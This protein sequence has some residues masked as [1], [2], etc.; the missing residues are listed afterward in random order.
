MSLMSALSNAR[1][2]LAVAQH[3]LDV[4]A[5]NV[6]NVNTEGYSRKL[7]QQEAVLLDGRGVGARSTDPQRAADEFLAARMR[8]QQARVGRSEALD[9]FQSAALDR[10]FGAP[11]DADRGLSTRITAA[12][13]AAETLAGSPS[14]A[15]KQAFIG[16]VDLLART[17]SSAGTEI[18]SLRHDA[19]QA[20]A[21]S[22]ADIN[23]D[24][25]VVE[26]LN[27]EI[28]RAGP[29]A[30]LLDQRDAAL[31]RIAGQIEITMVADAKGAVAVYT[32]GGA[33]LVGSEARQLHYEPAAVTT[34]TSTFW[35]ISIFRADEIDAAT[36][37]PLPGAAGNIVVTGG[38]RAELT[39][40]QEADGV[41]DAG[42]RIVSPFAQ[43]RLQGLLEARDRALPALA[44]E[45]NELAG[46][47][48][49]VL[50]AAHNAAVA[51]PPPDRLT[52]TRTDFSSL[53]GATR[54]GTAYL[55]VVDR[56]TGAVAATVELDVA[57]IDSPAA[58]AAR[59][60]AG[61]GALGA[62]TVNADGALELSA[63]SGFGLALAE[64]DGSIQVADATGRQRSFGLS[65]YFGLND[66]VQSA[67][68]G[69]TDL[70]VRPDLAKDSSRLGQAQLDVA[71]TPALAATLGGRG[72]Q[73]GAQGLAAAFD[74]ALAAPARGGLAGGSFKVADYAAEIAASTAAAAD[75]A[76]TRA[77]DD[78]SLAD[79]LALRRS[80]V[81]GVNLDEELSRMVVYQQAYAVSAR[82]I[83]VIDELFDQL[84]A[85][86]R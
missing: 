41:A 10:I 85:I 11:G 60:N 53:A 40:E 20:I 78:R 45:L 1:S 9:G 65:H 42:Q 35:P 86:G 46:M 27:Q 73:R 31:E 30:D 29:Q 57:A 63:A 44:D 50:N 24:L 16:A 49:H 80:G 67:G 77:A 74:R 56:S 38:V 23:R 12:A 32:R 3:A 51:L 58:L 25:K 81:S 13:R 54:S 36:G 33:S 26:R 61:L 76:A 66:L 72:D 37:E 15:N 39:P 8:E 7:V 71:T 75:T 5:N 43:G 14:A 22:V 47:V 59:I 19:D 18:Q 48:S 84:L 55:A 82:V 17:V 69:P 6:A 62:A 52:G 34:G 4:T 2:G 83:S 64:G 70:I 79:E 21:R 28:V 68:A